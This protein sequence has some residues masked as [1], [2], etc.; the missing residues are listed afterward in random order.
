MAIQ[1]NEIS[2]KYINKLEKSYFNTVKYAEVVSSI[3]GAVEETAEAVKDEIKNAIEPLKVKIA[4][5]DEFISSQTKVNKDLEIE[6]QILREKADNYKPIIKEAYKQGI[7]EEIREKKRTLAAILSGLVL[8]KEELNKP[9]AIEQ[10]IV[11]DTEK[12]IEKSVQKPIEEPVQ[13][14]VIS[15]KERTQRVYTK[16]IQTSKQKEK[17][18]VS[19]NIIKAIETQRKNQKLDTVRIAE[20]S[21]IIKNLL[22]EPL[23]DSFEYRDIQI[24]FKKT[25]NSYLETVRSFIEGRYE[26]VNEKYSIK[27]IGKDL[28]GRTLLK[29]HGT[30]YKEF[31]PY[32]YEIFKQDGSTVEIYDSGADSYIEYRDTNDKKLL[33]VCYGGYSEA[34]YSAFIYDKDG[35]LMISESIKDGVIKYLNVRFNEVKPIPEIK[36]DVTMNAYAQD[37]ISRA[38]NGCKS[39]EKSYN[40][41]TDI[42]YINSDGKVSVHEYFVN[43]KRN[44]NPIFTYLYDTQN[45]QPK[46][47]ITNGDFG[48][49][50]KYDEKKQCFV[51]YRTKG[52]TGIDKKRK[53]SD[54]NDFS[55]GFYKNT[56]NEHYETQDLYDKNYEGDK[57]SFLQREVYEK[58][59]F[60]LASHPLTKSFTFHDLTKHQIKP[61]DFSILKS[62]L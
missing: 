22:G 52:I 3:K 32:K 51:Q 43:K 6:N 11:K 9:K 55:I 27:R 40:D 44:A 12:Q 39:Q 13:K 62:Y 21:K 4:H 35:R 14:S 20:A 46:K 37:I 50:A 31:H 33:K 61:W 56:E 45:E 1:I 54:L 17:P 29:E 2:E 19:D 41:T 26:F 7:T 53:N 24:Q 49:H 28:D 60:G 18:I 23:Q 34:C 8:H 30:K 36:N 16:N 47:L 10:T 57:D 42:D 25:M 38:K 5:K 59:N 48:I 58:C 15:K